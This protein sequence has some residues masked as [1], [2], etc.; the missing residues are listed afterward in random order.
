ML[1]V[2]R[3]TTLRFGGWDVSSRKGFLNI[4]S[5]CVGLSSIDFLDTQPPSFH[6]AL[7]STCSEDTNLRACL[8]PY[9]SIWPWPSFLTYTQEFVAGVWWVNG[10][11]TDTLHF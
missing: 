7:E 11:L 2:R 9:V 1:E 6:P 10:C 5:L 3:I 4:E 8:F